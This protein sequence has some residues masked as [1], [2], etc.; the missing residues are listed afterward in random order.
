M[1][2]AVATGAEVRELPETKDGE[3]ATASKKTQARESQTEAFWFRLCERYKKY[4]ADNPKKNISQRAFLKSSEA[5]EVSGEARECRSFS[6]YW[7]RYERGELNPTSSRRRRRSVGYIEI[8]ERLATYLQLR[9]QLFI[10]GDVNGATWAKLKQKCVRW[11]LKEAK[12]TKQKEDVATDPKAGDETKEDGAGEAN[13][14]KKDNPYQ[15]FRASPGWLHKVLKR[16]NIESKYLQSEMDAKEE[17]AAMEEWIPSFHQTMVELNI[18][19]SCLYTAAQSGLL[20]RQFPATKHQ[21]KQQ[22]LRVES[23][24]RLTLM[25]CTAAD[26]TKVPIAAVGRAKIPFQED[27]DEEPEE[28]DKKMTPKEPPIPYTYQ[29]NAWFDKNITLWWIHNV[30]WPFHTSQHGDAP[31]VLL[32][33]YCPAHAGLDQE[34]GEQALPA[35][36]RIINFPI[37]MSRK[38]HPGEGGT[39]GSVKLGY[40]LKM[41]SSVSALFD[42]FGGFEGAQERYYGANNSN[43]R[44]PG[45]GGLAAGDPATIRDALYLLKQVWNTNSKFATTTLILEGWKKTKLLPSWWEE[46]I[47]VWIQN[48][49]TPR[50]RTQPLDLDLNQLCQVLQ[51]LASK[52]EEAGLERTKLENSALK[53]SYVLARRDGDPFRFED[54]NDVFAMATHWI[55]IEDDANVREQILEF[56]CEQALENKKRMI[57]LQR[58]QRINNEQQT[59][60]QVA[61]RYDMV[62][63]GLKDAKEYA[64]FLGMDDRYVRLLDRFEKQL[65]DAVQKVQKVKVHGNR[66]RKRKRAPVPTAEGGE[67]D[68]KPE[69]EGRPLVFAPET[70]DESRET[71]AV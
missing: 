41:A 26:G 50:T 17:H 63:K 9:S 1:D 31:C 52:A 45:T 53:G 46:E 14:D 32:L 60:S 36:L 33:D 24:D 8:E 11:G 28:S 44:D 12:E 69:L 15:D 22:K 38:R 70:N 56:E 59:Y 54:D 61:N 13:D 51:A 64:V 7:Q 2:A 58:L 21:G 57:A 4:Q 62:Q 19:G 67:Q 27:D 29:E 18:S 25:I 68:H 35:N 39:I 30:F 20:F 3:T 34:Q 42:L 23:D 37:N 6:R 71:S 10:R 65:T 55:E 43:N 48:G 66:G 16:N 49:A 5:L 40:K 47:D